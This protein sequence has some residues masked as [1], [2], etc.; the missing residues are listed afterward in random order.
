MAQADSKKLVENLNAARV[1]KLV[2]GADSLQVS[3]I[4]QLYYLYT[5]NLEAAHAIRVSKEFD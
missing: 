4:R 1:E 3:T 2:R 5:R